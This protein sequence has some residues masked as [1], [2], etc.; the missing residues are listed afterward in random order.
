MLDTVVA[1]SP[2]KSDQ[3]L[4]PLDVSH[5]NININIAPGSAEG[6]WTKHK[7]RRPEF[8]EEESREAL[9]PVKTHDQGKIEG[10][11]AMAMEYEGESADIRLYDNIIETVSGFAPP[12]SDASVDDLEVTDEIKQWILPT[13]KSQ[14]ISG[15]YRSVWEAEQESLKKLYMLGPGRQWSIRQDIG[16]GK[17]ADGTRRPPQFTITYIFRE[18]TEKERKKFRNRAL[19]ASILRLR[20]GGN[21]ERRTTNL[22]VVSE[23][24]DACI[25]EIRGASVDGKPVD[26]SNTSH[27]KFVLGNFKKNAILKFFDTLEADLGE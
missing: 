10:H 7:L 20:G 25:Q 17:N 12:G 3:K 4:Y 2:P 6:Y 21:E 16:A 13:W 15:I 9:M 8:G 19:N 26:A 1:V 5:F 18:P 22:R 11:D 23:L 27:L 24:F 14:A